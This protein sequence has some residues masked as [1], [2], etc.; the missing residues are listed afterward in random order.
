MNTR[1]TA[2]AVTL[3]IF[4]ALVTVAVVA[5]GEDS[6]N[7]RSGLAEATFREQGAPAVVLER[8][9]RVPAPSLA[10][11]AAHEGDD[12]YFVVCGS[13]VVPVGEVATF[14]L[15]AEGR[16]VR[17]DCGSPEVDWGDGE[18]RVV[19]LIECIPYAAA[20]GPGAIERRLEHSY[21]VPGTYKARFLLMNC[22]PD[23]GPQATV[24]LEVHVEG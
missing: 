3:A 11:C 19:C 12:P 9:A 24:A 7:V 10:P 14:D 8:D 6:S 21:R 13:T 18:L 5:S 16:G 1:K 2:G 23:Y 15:V 17:D 22:G 20:G 4:I